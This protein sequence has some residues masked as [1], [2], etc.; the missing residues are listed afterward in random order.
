M[1]TVAFS[2]Q[3]YKSNAESVYLKRI[4]L[5]SEGTYRCEVSGEAPEFKTAD[6]Q[7]EMKVYGKIK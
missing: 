2:V 3:I 4:N 5:N 6:A 7:K 1:S